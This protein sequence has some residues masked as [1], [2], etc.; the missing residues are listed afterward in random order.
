VSGVV[1]EGQY[2]NK[3]YTTTLHTA[4]V[5][6][7]FKQKNLN[8]KISCGEKIAGV[9]CARHQGRTSEGKYCSSVDEEFAAEARELRLE[10]AF[11]N[12]NPYCRNCVKLQDKTPG[13]VLQTEKCTSIHYYREFKYCSVFIYL[14][15]FVLLPI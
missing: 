4:R 12:S 14:F 2:R 3:L 6:F 8:E 10:R 9:V 1:V 5:V 7:S 13:L 15:L 11:V